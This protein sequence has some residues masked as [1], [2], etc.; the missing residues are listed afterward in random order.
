MHAAA[1]IDANEIRNNLVPYG[2]G[3]ADRAAGA[4]MCVGHYSYSGA[5]CERMVAQVLDLLLGQAFYVIGEDYRLIVFA[6][7]FF[8]SLILNL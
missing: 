1:N 8:H 4:G 2:H 3:R 7:D 6:D 5:G